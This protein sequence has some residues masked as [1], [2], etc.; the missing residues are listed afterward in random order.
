MSWQ[1]TFAQV[2]ISIPYRLTT[3]EMLN[4]DY[5]TVWYLDEAG[6]SHPVAS[7]KY[8][9]GAAAVTFTARHFSTYAVVMNRKSFADLGASH[10][11]KKPV[12]VLAAKGIVTGV[13]AVSFAPSAQIS[14]ADF[15]V[16]LIRAFGLDR[17]TAVAASG[18]T[19][20]LPD[21]YYYEAV[22]AAQR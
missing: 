7:D 3:A 12:E 22:N 13:S 5:L 20:V 14:R 19:V 17:R 21:S 9:S 18:F 4:S 8:D 15:V 2:R 16:M 10:W 6:A 11:A 1:D